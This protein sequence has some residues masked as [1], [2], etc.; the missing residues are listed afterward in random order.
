MHFVEAAGADP[1]GDRTLL[2]AEAD[3]FTPPHYPVLPIGEHSN[4]PLHFAKPQTTPLIGFVCG[5]GGGHL[6]I[7]VG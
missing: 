3:Q 7:R 4:P 5:L 1:S 2:K 6:W